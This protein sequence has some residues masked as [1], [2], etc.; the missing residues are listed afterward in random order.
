[1]DKVLHFIVSFLIAFAAL[2]LLGARGNGKGLP[3]WMVASA[4]VRAKR[5]LVL[6]MVVS[7]VGAAMVGLAKEV[8]DRMGY[9]NYELADMVANIAGIALAGF[10]FGST[11]SREIGSGVDFG[12]NNVRMRLNTTISGKPK[13]ARRARPARRGLRLQ[14][15]K[16]RKGIGD[17]NK[18]TE[19][20]RAPKALPVVRRVDEP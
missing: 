9:G 7:A 19:I 6:V 3:M 8:I 1:M 12:V 2:T 18:Q 16:A 13:D 20:G 10:C 14:S 11:R 5:I 17:G 15:Q 4:Q